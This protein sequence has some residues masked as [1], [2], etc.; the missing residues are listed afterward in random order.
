MLL[1]Q[2]GA[3]TARASMDNARAEQVRASWTTLTFNSNALRAR[4]LQ[5]AQFQQQQAMINMSMRA[6]AAEMATR[7]PSPPLLCRWFW[8]RCSWD[9]PL[10]DQTPPKHAAAQLYEMDMMAERARLA[11]SLRSEANCIDSEHRRML[12][13][14]QARVAAGCSPGPC[15]TVTSG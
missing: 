10:R 5:Q 12:A 15:S 3:T 13:A 6:Q 11:Q 14:A 8:T 1:A 9:G 4:Q 7:L 2:A